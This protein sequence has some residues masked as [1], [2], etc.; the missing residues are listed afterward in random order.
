[1]RTFGIDEPIRMT[2]DDDAPLFEVGLSA[3]NGDYWVR[4]KRG[5]RTLTI[6]GFDRLDTLHTIMQRYE[7]WEDRQREDGNSA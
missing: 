4:V 6:R 2:S 1:M 7:D 5:V 3:L